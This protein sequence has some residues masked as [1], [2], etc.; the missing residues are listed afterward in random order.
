MSATPPTDPK[1]WRQKLGQ[2]AWIRVGLGA[3]SGLLSGLL[4]FVTIGLTTANPNAYYGF[5]VAFFVY[6]LSYYLAKY[7]LIKQ[8]DPKNKNKLITQ[9]IGSYIMMFIFVWI[10]FNTSCNMFGCMHF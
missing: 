3:L 10:L 4:G 5:Y 6:V 8:V 9:G 7:V 2:L 1:I